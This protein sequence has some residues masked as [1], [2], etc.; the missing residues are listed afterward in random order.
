MTSAKTL[1]PKRPYSEVL[2]GRAFGGDALQPSAFSLVLLSSHKAAA[3]ESLE[4]ESSPLEQ[5]CRGCS[6]VS[7]SWQFVRKKSAHTLMTTGQGSVR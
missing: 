2:G 4:S 3:V 5:G 1:F 7:G 6:P